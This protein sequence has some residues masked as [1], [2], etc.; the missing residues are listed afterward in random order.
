MIKTLY[1]NK[2]EY[3]DDIIA[4]YHKYN[5]KEITAEMLKEAHRSTHLEFSEIKKILNN[6]IDTLR[7]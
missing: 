2:Q 3:Y 4:I 7:K 5:S 1:P 6:Y